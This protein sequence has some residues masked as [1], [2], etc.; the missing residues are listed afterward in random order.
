[1]GERRMTR[2][3]QV[4]CERGPHQENFTASTSQVKCSSVSVSMVTGPLSLVLKQDVVGKGKGAVPA[5]LF[6]S[7]CIHFL[8]VCA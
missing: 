8:H 5:P 3:R 2:A 6:Q 4:W 7:V 1:M